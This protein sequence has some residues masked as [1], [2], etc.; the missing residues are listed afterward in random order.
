M[1]KQ[2]QRRGASYYCNDEERATAT[3]GEYWG[4]FGL[5]LV[6]RTCIGGF[7][8]FFF[9]KHSTGVCFAFALYRLYWGLVFSAFFAS[10]VTIGTVGL[11]SDSLCFFF[12]FFENPWWVC[13]VG[14]AV[15]LACHGLGSITNFFFFFRF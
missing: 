10:D 11:I 4:F 13:S 2:R 1:S 15:G 7:F 9:D 6:Q 5:V 12:F 14:L 3:T 8:F